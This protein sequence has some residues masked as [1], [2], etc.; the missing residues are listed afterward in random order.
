VSA[1]ALAFAAPVIATHG[2]TDP[3][4]PLVVLLHGRG[5]DEQDILGLATALPTGPAYAAVRAPIAE[6]SGYAWFANRG[7]GRPVV[8]SLRA[9]MDWF[10]EWLDV[11]APSGRPVLLV[12]FSGGAAFAGGLVLDEPARYVGAAILCGTMPFDAGVPTT[13][14]RLVGLPMFV[15]QGAHDTVIPRDLLDGTWDYLT[16]ESGAPTIARRDASGHTLTTGAANQLSEWIRERIAFLTTRE[17]H[18]VAATTGTTGWPTLDAGALPPR[19]G[20]RPD[21]SM[22]IP[23]QQTTDNAPTDLQEKLFEAVLALP[24]VRTG[25]SVLSV[26]GARGFML[27]GG[28]G[29]DDAFLVTSVREFAHLHPSFDGSLH[30]ALPLRLAADAVEKGWAVAHPLAGI[31]LTPGM[32]MIYGPRTDVELATVT[33]IVRTSYLYASGEALA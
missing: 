32:V 2:S 27:E 17:A 29:P 1:E 15:A 20:R 25:Q 8:T 22:S 9:T 31:R 33:G 11:V 24:G 16:G 7:I 18:T 13:P 5:A 10:R 19:R 6:G 23:Q 12:G 3:L 30:L 4:A 14:A 21:V 28:G 26:P